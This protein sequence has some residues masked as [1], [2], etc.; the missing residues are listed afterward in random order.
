MLSHLKI[1]TKNRIQLKL[2]ERHIIHATLWAYEPFANILKLET[3]DAKTRLNYFHMPEHAEVI[4]LLCQRHLFWEI[5]LDTN[6]EAVSRVLLTWSSFKIQPFLFRQSKLLV[7]TLLCVAVKI[8]RICRGAKGVEIEK[9]KFLIMDENTEWI[10]LLQN[11]LETVFIILGHDLQVLECEM[12]P[13][14]SYRHVFVPKRRV[15]NWTWSIWIFS[16]SDIFQEVGQC[17]WILLNTLLYSQIDPSTVLKNLKWFPVNFL[18]KTF[19]PRSI[20]SGLDC[21]CRS[22]NSIGVKLILE[23]NGLFLLICSDRGNSKK[24]KEENEKN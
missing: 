16:K 1:K 7:E 12:T 5:F 18:S 2:Q 3:A 24:V 23:N 11:K 10:C 8:P 17:D 6:S 19:P 4:I 13:P 15:Q 21:H 14:G 9:K 22:L 20:L